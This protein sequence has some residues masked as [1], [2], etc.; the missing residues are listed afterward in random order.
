MGIPMATGTV[1]WFNAQKGFGFI[2]PSN[3]GKD[4]F[5]HISAVERAGLATL[6]EGQKISYDVV[7]ERGKDA[8]ANLKVG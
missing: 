1:K 8:A 5:V 7:N 3:G 6:Q 4:V 2:Q